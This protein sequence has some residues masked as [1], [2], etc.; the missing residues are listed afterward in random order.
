MYLDTS[1][2]FAFYIYE[3]KSQ[4][5][6]NIIQEADSVYISALTDVEFYSALKKRNRMG[7]ISKKDV[8]KTYSLYK[9]H[10]NQNLYH[11]LGVEDIHFKIAEVILS[12]TSTALRTLDAIHLGISDQHHIPIFSFDSVLQKAATEFGI[13]VIDYSG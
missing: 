10:R 5:A 11:F 7:E 4:L 2:L 3:E 1:A 9:N 8:H 12:K 13:N 6:V